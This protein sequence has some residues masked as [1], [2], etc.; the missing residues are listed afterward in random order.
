[1]RVH[2]LEMTAF[3]PFAGTEVIDFDALSDAGIFLLTGQTGAGKTTIL[4]AICFGLFGSVPG[5]RNGAKD[6]KSHHATADS[7]PVVVLEVTVRGRRLR[8][9]R[10][11]SWRRPSRRA[12]LG[13]VDQH[14]R[15]SVE[16]LVDGEWVA[17]SARVDDVSLLVTRVLGMNREQFCQVVMLPQGLFQ[18]FLR[19]GAKERHDVLESLFETTRF[20]RI[21]AY[22]TDHRRGCERAVDA[23]RAAICQLLARADEVGTDETHAQRLTSALGELDAGSGGFAE[24]RGQLAAL[25]EETGADAFVARQEEATATSEAKDRRHALDAARDLD[26][27]QR[28]HRA[29]LERV[30]ALD[31][32]REVVVDRARLVTRA[33]AARSFGPL[34]DLLADGDRELETARLRVDTVH[35]GSVDGGAVDGEGVDASVSAAR[36]RLS[37]LEAMVAVEE[38][39]QR[40]TQRVAEAQAELGLIE[41]RRDGQRTAAEQVPGLLAEARGQLL[42]QSRL[43]STL[44]TVQLALS[45]AEARAVAAHEEVRVFTELTR[46]TPQIRIALDCQ[47][48]ARSRW[49]DLREERLQGMAAELAGRLAD[50]EPCLVCG[51]PTHPHPAAADGRQVSAEAEAAAVDVLQAHEVEHTRLVGLATAL[52]SGLAAAAAVSG[53][54]DPAE[55][56]EEVERARQ[57]V[58]VAITAGSA[59]EELAGLVESLEQRCRELDDELH[60]SDTAHAVVQHRLLV[61]G[62]ELD[63]RSSELSRVVEPGSRVGALVRAATT[64]LTAAVER[65]EAMRDLARCAQVRADAVSRLTRALQPTD[66]ADVDDLRS[67]AMTD[68][69]VAAA[70]ALNR[71]YDADYRTASRIVDDPVLAAAAGLPLPDL[72]AL[73]SAAD[74]AE[75]RRATARAGADRLAWRRTRLEELL[76]RLHTALAEWAPLVERR[77]LAVGVA[78]MCAGTSPDNLSRTRLSHYVLAAR[79]A[80]VVAAGNLRLAGIF[81]GRYQLG[82]SMARGVGDRRGGLGLL[83]LD[84]YTG[85]RRDPAT[86][87]GGETFYVSLALAL[88]LADL[89]RDEVGGAE[90]STLFV[91]EGFGSLDTQTLDEVM[92]EIDSL[93]SGGR[94]VGLVSHLTELSARVPMQLH[95]SAG[96]DG[97]TIRPPQSDLDSG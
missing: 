70:D 39:A 5:A 51:S 96:R 72:V 43:G 27:R 41:R 24:A 93:R 30:R 90:L 35:G 12:G 4:D 8:T 59:H 85:H 76:A 60:A 58:D 62:A 97:S 86:L 19:A 13:Y 15:A 84:T 23:Q 57:A 49:L 20:G 42:V 26:E 47:L 80:Q 63:E 7:V 54:L 38:A 52:Q 32:L 67:A 68:A 9:R 53:G 34:L 33:D 37:Q 69:D 50:G 78:A 55:A 94:C 3:G 28:T 56:Q 88:G 6:L 1:M 71:A 16:E 44:A 11:P 17:L 36:E 66:F 48:S 61:L 65:A 82:H 14:A 91:D 2:S 21:E 77:D 25:V 73:E 92:D 31:A 81:G 22:L 83:V 79:L 89:V 95:V 74:Q 18:T 46:L 45:G 64:A 87:S 40:L 10:S 75:A 29:G